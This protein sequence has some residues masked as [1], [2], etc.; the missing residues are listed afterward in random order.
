MFPGRANSFTTFWDLCLHSGVLQASPNHQNSRASS[1]TQPAGHMSG[2]GIPPHKFPLFF[3]GLLFVLLSSLPWNAWDDE[4][5]SRTLSPG[6][7]SVNRGSDMKFRPSQPVLCTV[8]NQGSLLWI[9]ADH[10]FL[11]RAVHIICIPFPGPVHTVLSRVD[12]H[13]E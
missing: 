11:D 13:E 2:K 8:P 4:L 7:L 1:K 9:R 3:Q 5:T 10:L 12:C 6:E